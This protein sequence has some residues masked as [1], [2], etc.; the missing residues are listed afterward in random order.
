MEQIRITRRALLVG[1][2]AAALTAT[3]LRADAATGEQRFLLGTY[4]RSGGRGIAVGRLDP[5]TGAPTVDAWTDAVEDPSWLAVSGPTLYAVS[6]T[7]AGAAHALRLGADGAPQPLNSR[8]TGN[9]PA[10]AAVSPDGAFLVTAMYGGGTVAVHPLAADGTVGEASDVQRHGE[11]AHPHQVVFAPD[12]AVLVVDLG[13]D[14]VVSYA[15][16][17]DGRLTKTSRAAFP[18]RT[19]PRHLAFDPAGDRA[20]VAGELNSTVTVCGYADGV[21]TPGASVFTLPPQTGVA[22]FP[23]EIAVAPGGGHVYVSNR[24]HNSVAVLTVTA[25]G[26][27]FTDAHPCGGDWPRHLAL[28]PTGG[29]LYVAN[30]RSGDVSWFSVDPATGRPTPA[31]TLA[32]AG[33]AQVLIA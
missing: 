10:H 17:G 3:A 26:L 19:G 31:G 9:G 8:P 5:V 13:L 14:A 12:G 2:A 11:G 20:Y 27:T 15:L 6:E 1:G 18:A 32:A 16:D 25:D 24:G 22:N 33:V 28:D 30:Q 23:G 29:W 21:L 4:T 7:P